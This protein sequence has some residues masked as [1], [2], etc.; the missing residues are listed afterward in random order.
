METSYRYLILLLV[1]LVAL[2]KTRFTEINEV[3]L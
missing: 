3:A 1:K 2:I